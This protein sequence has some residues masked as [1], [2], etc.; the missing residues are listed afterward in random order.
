MKE[1]KKISHDVIS[2]IENIG[3]LV[4][5]ISTVIAVGVEILSMINAWTIR[6]AD[7]LILFIYLEVLA[8][9]SIYLESGKLP[10]QIPL[11]ITIVA[12][13]RYMILDMKGLDNWRMIGVAGS[14]LLI[15][16]SVLVYRYGNIKFPYKNESV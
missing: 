5:A 8:M 10:V 15:S 2:F 12:L 7:L 16:F 3:L 1:I 11:Y 14:I 6:L 4:I 9:V 13:S